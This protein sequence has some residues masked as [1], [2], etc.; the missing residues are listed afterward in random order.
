MLQNGSWPRAAASTA[1]NS[2]GAIVPR[3]SAVAWPTRGRVAD[4]SHE[5]DPFQPEVRIPCRVI[6]GGS[7]LC[8]PVYC[9]RYRPH[10]EPADTSPRAMS[11]SD[12]SGEEPLLHHTQKRET[13]G[14]RH[15]PFRILA[16]ASRA[17]NMEQPT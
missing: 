7:H 1:P 17:M 13:Y 3:R 9:R 5:F 8:A 11:V 10:A 12:A 4:R 16:L 6:K 14:R 15:G 2:C